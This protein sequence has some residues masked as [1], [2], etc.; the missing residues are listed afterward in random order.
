M[1]D[2]GIH[3][4]YVTPIIFALITYYF[5][6]IYRYKGG[7]FLVILRAGLFMFRTDGNRTTTMT[8]VS[9]PDFDFCRRLVLLVD[10]LFLLETPVV[11]GHRFETEYCVKLEHRLIAIGMVLLSSIG[12][13]N[14]K[15]VTDKTKLLSGGTFSRVAWRA[16]CN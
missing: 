1:H 3:V 14:S 7:T 2:N 12:R 15:Y 6:A 4:E 5:A 10:R 9:P 8:V 11:I 16:V 13:K